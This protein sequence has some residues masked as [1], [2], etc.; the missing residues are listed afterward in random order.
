MER[1]RYPKK[2]G[3]S[4]GEDSWES[5]HQGKSKGRKAGW[6]SSLEALLVLCAVVSVAVAVDGLANA[7]EIYRGVKVAGTPVGGESPEEAAGIL[8]SG[9]QE[10]LPAEVKLSGEGQEVVLSRDQL[11]AR[12]AVEDSVE[13]AYEVGRTGGIGGRVLE[14][15]KASLGMVD[16]D[17]RVEYRDGVAREAVEGLARNA[18]GTPQSAAVV[19]SEGRAEVEPAREGYGVDRDATVE[20]VRRGIENLSGEARIVGGP[21]EP[22]ITTAEAEEAAQ[23]IEGALA[24]PL[25]LEARDEEWTLEPGQVAQAIEVANGDARIQLSVN[26][27]S[28]QAAA[29]NLYEEMSQEPKDATYVVNEGSVEVEP[30]QPGMRVDQDGLLERLN[31]GLFEGQNRFEVPLVESGQP[32]LTTEEARS[33]KPTE[34]I[35]EFKSD[36]SIVDDPDGNR[37]ENLRIASGAINGTLLA[38]GEVFSFNDNAAHLEYKESKVFQEGLIQKALG[39]GL[40]QVASTMY[41]A[42]NY[43]GLEIVER[44]QHYSMLEYIKPGFDSTVWFGDYYGNGELDSRFKNTTD[45]YVLLR[46]WVDD[47]GFM[48]AEVWGQPTGKKVEMRSEEVDWTNSSSTWVTY[49]KVTENG[50]VIEDGPVYEDTYRSLGSNEY[51]ENPYDFDPVWTWDR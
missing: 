36:Y 47:D 7:G 10:K 1:T 13:R 2:R 35:G 44:H 45:G 49:K 40:C 27:E 48:H 15:V 34:L 43:A 14:R 17:P 38:P 21:V 51:N 19:F 37:T 25:V 20:N 42:A 6:R 12:F 16:V 8:G 41:M 22:E 4:S 31:S 29:G 26:G 3:G 24:E 30:G 46:Q 50:E 23:K 32:G 18:G 33:L 11:G 39:G 28:L 9:L 5:R